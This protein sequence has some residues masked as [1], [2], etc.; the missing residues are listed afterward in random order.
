MKTLGLITA[1]MMI[2]MLAISQDQ[3]ERVLEAL[4]STLDQYRNTPLLSYNVEYRYSTED[5]PNTYLDSLTGSFKSDGNKFLSE[6]NQIK[7]V[8]DGEFV[9]IIYPEDSVI[10]LSKPPGMLNGNPAALFDSSFINRNIQ[11]LITETRDLKILTLNFIDDPQ[12]K[13]IKYE[14]D[15]KS[16]WIVS[17]TQKVNQA[18]LFDKEI[19]ATMISDDKYG[20]VKINF[21]QYE[22]SKFDKEVFNYGFYVRKEGA[23]YKAQ[24]PFDL[25]KVFLGSSNL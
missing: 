6:I 3:K 14:I 13:Q 22:K 18:L 24:P 1:F 8:F 20:L 25:Y 7:T 19:A 4:I 10:Y 2:G 11:Y 23:E 9:V 15:K 16:G 5:Q 21:S 12:Y 17:V